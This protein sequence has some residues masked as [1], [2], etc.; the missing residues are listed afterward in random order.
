MSFDTKYPNRKDIRKQYHGR[1][2]H[3][4]S[5]RPHG[6]CSYCEKSRLHSTLKRTLTAKEKINEVDG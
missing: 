3:D 6:G 2:K 1:G 5:C 4:G